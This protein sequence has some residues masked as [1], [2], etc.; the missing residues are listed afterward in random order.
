MSTRSPFVAMRTDLVKDERV[1][2]IADTIGVTRDEVL[3]KLF[4]LWAWCTDRKLEDAPDDCAGYAVHEAI[5]RRFLGPE[6]PR[7]MLGDGCAELALGDRRPDGLVFLHGTETVV[8][9]LRALYRRSHAG[10]IARADM[11]QVDGRDRGKF[12]RTTTNMPAPG[13]ASTTDHP[14]PD[15]DQKRER[16]RSRSI[17]QV[18]GRREVSSMSSPTPSGPDTPGTKPPPA[19]AKM[20][21]ERERAAAPR[22]LTA[23]STGH[24]FTGVVYDPEDPAHRGRLAADVYRRVS[25]ARV[26]IAAELGLPEQLPFPVI[27]PSSRAGSYRELLDRVR[28]EGIAAPAACARVVDNL[29][30]QAREAREIE[31]LAEKAFTAG[32]WRTARGWISKKP[33][34]RPRPAADEQPRPREPELTDEDRDEIK[35]LALRLAANPAAGVDEERSRGRLPTRAAPSSSTDHEPRKAT[36]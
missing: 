10:G 12:V 5:I 15:P 26:A 4:R 34:P 25:D 28:E 23:P 20:S 13:P 11:A 17:E 22:Q 14:D 18:E 33:K 31:W 1:Q 3:G 9:S 7:A 24:V 2:F 30:A 21:P 6:G 27:A 19:S 16:E 36:S 35:S 32:G 8:A 29:I